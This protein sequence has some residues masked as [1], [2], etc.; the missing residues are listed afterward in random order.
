MPF[1]RSL[2]FLGIVILGLT[3]RGQARV[4]IFKRDARLLGDFGAWQLTGPGGC[5]LFELRFEF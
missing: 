5:D 2:G 3:P 1:V 4:L